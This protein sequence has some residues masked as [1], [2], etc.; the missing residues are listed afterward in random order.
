MKRAFPHGSGTPMNPSL[1]LASLLLVG[2]ACLQ[3][4]DHASPLAVVQTIALPGVEGRF[5]HAAY[6]PATHR[7][8][9]AA[10]GNGSLEVVDTQAGARVHSIERLKKPT[11]VLWLPDS[12]QLVVAC[13]NEGTVRFYDGASYELQGSVN[14]LDDADNLRFDRPANRIYVGY[15]EG[16]LGVIDPET[17]TLVASIALQAHPEAFQLETQGK[18]IFVNVPDAQHVAV[19]DREQA[20]VIETWPLGEFHSNF[21]MALDEA[22]QR[23]YIGCRRPARLLV[24]DTQSGK[25]ASDHALRGD[26]DDFVLLHET[27]RLFASCGEGFLDSF[28]LPTEGGPIARNPSTPTARGARTC[29]HFPKENW[30]CVAVPR[31]GDQGAELRFYGL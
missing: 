20:K 12:K 19:V 30:L 28:R 26:I 1:A 27:Q 13:G 17:R 15:G 18:R 23:L 9:F 29:F 22:G 7:L 3:E 21:P 25:V 5:D 14:K 24:L 6:D 2:P 16:A 31:Y 10:L 4:S 8:F 11:G